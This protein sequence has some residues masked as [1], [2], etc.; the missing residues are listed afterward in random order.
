MSNN[1]I[2]K[3]IN[4]DIIH[5]AELDKIIKI[6]SSSKYPPNNIINLYSALT[7]TESAK[8][9]NKNLLISSN[10]NNIDENKINSNKNSINKNNNKIPNNKIN[11]EIRKKLHFKNMKCQGNSSSTN[12]KSNN[13]IFKT[14]VL[15]SI[16]S[17]ISNINNIVDSIKMNINYNKKYNNINN[18]LN[19]RKSKEKNISSFQDI[20]HNTFRNSISE[21]KIKFPKRLEKNE[22]DLV[23]TGSEPNLKL[24]LNKNNIEYKNEVKKEIKKAFKRLL[25]YNTN[26][27]HVS[28]KEMKFPSNQLINYSNDKIEN[29]FTDKDNINKKINDNFFCNKDLCY[30]YLSGRN[31]RINK[32]KINAKQKNY[33]MYNNYDIS[34]FINE[35]YNSKNNSKKRNI[36]NNKKN[37]VIK[38]NHIENF[39]ERK[40]IDFNISGKQFKI[41]NNVLNNNYTIKYNKNT[42]D[43]ISQLNLINNINNTVRLNSNS[44][45]KSKSKTKTKTNIHKKIKNKN[46]YKNNCM[47]INKYKEYKKNIRKNKS[48]NNK[49]FEKNNIILLHSNNSKNKEKSLGSKTK[50]NNKNI[51][52]NININDIKTTNININ[53][54]NINNEIRKKIINN[55]INPITNINI[56]NINTNINNAINF[57]TNINTTNL[58]YLTKT[59]NNSKN[60]IFNYNY[61]KTK[62]TKDIINNDSLPLKNIFDIQLKKNK[63]N[64]NIDL[65]ESN[66]NLIEYNNIKK[67]QKKNCF[68]SDNNNNKVSMFNT[69]NNFNL[70]NKDFYANKNKIES[71]KNSKEKKLLKNISNNLISNIVR[72]EDIIFQNNKFLSYS[73]SKRNTLSSN[74]KIKVKKKHQT[75]NIN[76]VFKNKKKNDHLNNNLNKFINKYMT[77]FKFNSTYTKN[78]KEKNF[79]NKHLNNKGAKKYYSKIIKNEPILP[80]KLI[81]YF[82]KYLKTHELEELKQLDK[83]KGMV[84]FIGEIRTR[85]N[86]DENTHI[87]IFHSTNNLKKIKYNENNL[88]NI[89]EINHCPSCPNLRAQISKKLNKIN[90][91]LEYT[92]PNIINKFNFNDKEGD[93]LFKKGYHLNYRYE[94]I[95]L[96]GKGSF[97]EAIKCFD[98]K[99]KEIVCIKIINSREEFQTQAM[100]EIKILTS[101]SL[102]D[103][104]NETGNVKFY[105]YFNF[106]GHICIVFELLGYNLYQIL[107]LN[108]FSGLSLEA[109]RYY[110]T[111]ILFSLMF[112]RRLKIIHCDL[113]PENILLEPNNNNKVKIIDFGSSCLQYEIT[114]SYIQSRFYRA[115]EVIMDLGYGYEI[116]IWSLGCILCELFSGEPIFPGSDELEQINYIMKYLGPPPQF[117]IENSPKSNYFFNEENNKN[118]SDFINNNYDIRYKKKNIEEFLNDNNFNNLNSNNNNILFDNFVDFICKCLEWNPK[119]RINPEEGLMHPFIIEEFSKEQLC[120]HKLK[121]KRIEN[122]TSQGVFTY[123]E[124]DKEI[125]LISKNNFFNINFKNNN[126]LRNYKN[127]KSF[128]KTPLN[129]SIIKNDNNNCKIIDNYLNIKNK[130]YNNKNNKKDLS[131]FNSYSDYFYKKTGK[132]KTSSISNYIQLSSNENHICNIK[133]MNYNKIK[134]SNNNNLI[135]IIANI[136]L[137]IK[138]IIKRESSGKYSNN[139]KIKKKKKNNHCLP[140]KKS[141]GRIIHKNNYL[142]KKK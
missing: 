134:Q 121:I 31:N 39:N 5:I 24:S 131:Y 84:Y 26:F 21:K 41:K 90:K 109:I 136:D 78:I 34:K 43:S 36:L 46:I 10:S 8:T 126:N 89:S 29:T 80:Q 13:S 49:K 53:N 56:N 108:D 142:F 115:P 2:P 111:D 104:N 102:N 128:N 125:S 72:I 11:D 87:I 82:Y 4:K 33:N 130:N 62:S 27:K 47:N 85:I 79:E 114:Y 74:N 17:H 30:N 64:N 48:P 16:K 55:N 38:S 110:T 67:G 28:L 138:K 95:E 106:R 7:P 107:Q 42:S 54:F 23:Y 92:N 122:K 60:N 112:L 86:K 105:H 59:N 70:K 135:N 57:I 140:K 132:R 117:C 37:N 83:N 6:K 45:S 120:K 22:L 81:K 124:K 88:K 119:D 14:K 40:T 141:L 98:H 32:N 9:K 93:Y 123:R 75:Q 61:K 127:S 137:N 97:G 69:S 73:N 58:G 71:M 133:N 94:I 91:G 77:K 63:I 15:K 18:N 116:D 65:I 96:L 68:S 100:V 103:I 1:F 66:N 51:N 118:Y 76:K 99:S 12:I 139:K 19:K 52:I 3:R 129:I 101:I 20:N 35:T 44:I 25:T 113:K 50:T